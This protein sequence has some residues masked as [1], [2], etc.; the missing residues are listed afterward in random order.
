MAANGNEECKA[1]SHM[2]W[3]KVGEKTQVKLDSNNIFET[4]Y[5]F[6]LR[7]QFCNYIG[8]SP[9]DP[10]KRKPGRLRRH[11]I[12]KAYCQMIKFLGVSYVCF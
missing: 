6:D 9:C 7:V 5:E 11:E 4:S 8:L 1:K 12:R 10:A 2:L 3:T